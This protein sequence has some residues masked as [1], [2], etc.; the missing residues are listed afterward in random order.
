MKYTCSVCK[1]EK[2]SAEF[3]A[4]KRNTVKGVSSKCKECAKAYSKAHPE[5]YTEKSKERA[6]K[7]REDN[8]EHCREQER[9]KRERNIDS[10]RA[11]SRMWSK[12][13]L[14]VKA[15]RRALQKNSVP[16]W[17]ESEKI[18]TVYQKARLFGMAVDHIVPLKHP[19]VCGLHVWSNLQ[20][21]DKG[22]NSS[23]R[24]YYWPDMPDKALP[25]SKLQVMTTP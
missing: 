22:M 25:A 24:N 10:Y 18:R 20:L 17:A 23:K 15:E 5:P 2:E 3:Y 6:K 9:V 12:N 21:L 13:N 8:L 7:W 1:S 19:L 16:D 11:A 4:D 14:H